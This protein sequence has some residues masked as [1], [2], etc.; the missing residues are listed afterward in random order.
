MG[1]R[2]AFICKGSPSLNKDS[3]S[4]GDL[5]HLENNIQ[6][7]SKL[8]K[9]LGN[10]ELI[11]IDLKNPADIKNQINNIEDSDENEILFFYTGHGKVVNSNF[12]L[13]G[14]EDKEIKF[15]DSVICKKFVKTSV[16]IILDAC[17]SG[18]V[19]FTDPVY[20]IITATYSNF[21]YEY[22]KKE[23]PQ[24]SYFTHYLCTFIE[25]YVYANEEDFQLSILGDLIKAKKDNHFRSN[26]KP[27]Y[28]PPPSNRHTKT[29]IIAYS[30]KEDEFIGQLSKEIKEQKSY[31]E[32]SEIVFMYIEPSPLLNDKT[33]FDMISHLY[34]LNSNNSSPFA[35]MLKELE[36]TETIQLAINVLEKKYGKSNC[37]KINRY[38]DTLVVD[39]HPQNDTYEL[40]V[41]GQNGSK[42]QSYFNF[43]DNLLEN[44][45]IEK[46]SEKIQE[47]KKLQEFATLKSI[48]LILPNN[49]LDLD[50][51][52]LQDKNR[53][54]IIDSNIFI[55]LRDRNNGYARQAR[56]E[57]NWN[58]YLQNSEKEVKTLYFPFAIGDS[59]DIV[60]KDRREKYPVM[61]MDC[62]MTSEISD[63]ICD[64][65]ISIIVY[66]LKEFEYKRFLRR[67]TLNEMLGDNRFKDS[68]LNELVANINRQIR[69]NL[70]NKKSHF[71]L[72]WDDPTTLPK[73]IT[74][75]TRDSL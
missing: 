73:N 9:K 5:R 28:F 71:A 12:C 10:W 52:K 3:E 21:A 7:V 14:K 65:G 70:K 31:K 55:K 48:V 11:A 17:H 34:H 56:W 16:T 13:V 24:L 46:L 41:Y 15:V 25:S 1:C 59:T 66:P 68:K 54:Y 50:Y 33:F 47:L 45:I 57:D 58:L 4:E 37:K 8:L 23:E 22:T 36:R 44:E 49:L 2:I 40:S 63:T 69:D 53:K 64:N 30:Q 43:N 60:N 29:N 6:R 51:K 61:V 20:E 42:E 74:N 38:F 18:R 26:Q 39:L 67:K 62:K 75:E 35:C 32:F 27:T 72:I 19:S